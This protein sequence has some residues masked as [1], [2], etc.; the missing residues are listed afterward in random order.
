MNVLVKFNAKNPGNKVFSF[1][2]VLD[3][4]L[5]AI[6]ALKK[7]GIRTPKD[8][9]GRKI[10]APVWDNSRIL[11]PIFA[12]ANGFSP[13]AVNWLSVKPTIRDSL[14]LAARPTRCPRSRPR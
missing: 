3:N 10:A 8:L 2:I 11:F 1:Y 5:S 4:T 6:V 7:S 9:V 12:N 13:D 14:L